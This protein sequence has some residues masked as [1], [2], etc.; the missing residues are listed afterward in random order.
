[1][2]HPMRTIAILLGLSILINVAIGFTAG[3]WG[4]VYGSKPTISRPAFGPKLTAIAD[5]LGISPRGYAQVG[6]RRNMITMTVIRDWREWT[7]EH[8]TFVADAILYEGFEIGWPFKCF[9]SARTYE[10]VIPSSTNT[11]QRY[12]TRTGNNSLWPQR[13]LPGLIPNVFLYA[14]CLW[15][16]SLLPRWIDQAFMRRRRRIRRGRCPECA[17]DLKG[18]LGGGCPECGWQRPEMENAVE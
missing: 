12:T 1:M 15:L 4:D 18:D 5:D 16:V 17:Y 14:A 7:N 2:K 13:V 9:E 6:S 8:G 10:L 11:V 3:I